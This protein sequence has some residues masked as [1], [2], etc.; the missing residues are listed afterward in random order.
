MKRLQRHWR[1]A[2]VVVFALGAG[3]WV[4]RSAEARMVV[5]VSEQRVIYTPLSPI[6][7]DAIMNLLAEVSLDRDALVGL[8]LSTS[9]AESVVAAVRSWY[10]SNLETLTG[11]DQTAQQKRAAVYDL[12]KA[13]AMGPAD[14]QRD[15]Q[16]AL[17]RQDFQTVK[18]SYRSGL[19]SLES[20]V[21]NL[22]SETQRS[23][24]AAI[25]VGHGRTMPIRLLSLTDAQRLAIGDAMQRYERQH[26]A[27]SDE[28]ARG[29][30]RT[31]WESAK[32][33]ILTVD[34]RNVIQAYQ[35][36]FA[37]ASQS[38]ATALDTVLAVAGQS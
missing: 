20:T 3:A 15:A 34:Q 24:W 13:Q 1:L 18:A 32:D 28:T 29:S 2:T 37:A 27:A 5:E 11:L 36:N 26:A 10:L 35:S 9:Q 12:E 23:I 31:T 16:L 21:S 19:S 14:A 22:L 17:A 33:S 38:A 30:A 7:R 25:K 6:Q 8:N 4:W